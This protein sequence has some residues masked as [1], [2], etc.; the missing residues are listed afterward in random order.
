MDHEQLRAISTRTLISQGPLSDAQWAVLQYAD[1][2]TTNLEVEE[3]LFQEVKAAGLDEQAIVE[4]TAVVAG[5]NCVS[6][7][8]IALEVDQRIG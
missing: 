8:L 1:A 4:L 7:F 2:M 3:K 6:R 5:Y